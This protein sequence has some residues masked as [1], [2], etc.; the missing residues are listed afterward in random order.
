MDRAQT[1]QRAVDKYIRENYELKYRTWM[2]V[3][4]DTNYLAVYYD[5]DGEREDVE[6]AFCETLA[7]GID[8]GDRVL[9][10]I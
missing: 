5:V 10:I 1:I 7:P 3:N 9:Y 2:T 4:A 6:R 8:D